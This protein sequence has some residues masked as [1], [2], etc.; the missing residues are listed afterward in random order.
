M[1]FHLVFFPIK[2]L[3]LV[4]IDPNMQSH[5]NNVFAVRTWTLFHHLLFLPFSSPSTIFLLSFHRFLQ[6]RFSTIPSVMH[7]AAVG[8]LI[9]C[10]N[11]IDWWLWRRRSQWRGVR[12]GNLDKQNHLSK[13]AAMKIVCLNC[14]ERRT[15]PLST[16]MSPF[17]LSLLLSQASVELLK[18]W[19]VA[20]LAFVSSVRCLCRFMWSLWTGS[21]RTLGKWRIEMS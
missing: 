1:N 13:D 10:E 7:M 16:V 12:N 14:A 6:R 17:S 15:M 3:R 2:S 18:V 8:S 19:T 5:R 11:E 21:S 4:Q 9:D 20:N